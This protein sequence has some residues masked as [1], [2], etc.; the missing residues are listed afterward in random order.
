MAS[1]FICAQVFCA[2]IF[3]AGIRDSSSNQ[4]FEAAVV[5]AF[6]DESLKIKSPEKRQ[7]SCLKWVISECMS[8][9]WEVPPENSA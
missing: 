4:L 1:G 8:R 5:F 2:D 9:R 3:Q 6:T 7:S